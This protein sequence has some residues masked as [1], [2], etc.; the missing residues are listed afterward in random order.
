MKIV[1]GNKL[2]ALLRCALWGNTFGETLTAKQF[3]RMMMLAEEQTVAGLVFE[4]L[5]DCQ[6]EELTDKKP[7]YKAVGRTEQIKQQ[8]NA[9]EFLL[10]KS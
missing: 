9:Y 7:I 6:I 5:K 2:F 3:Q 10:N 8:I 4:V 1:C